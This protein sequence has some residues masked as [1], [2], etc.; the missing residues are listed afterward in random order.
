MPADVRARRAVT[1]DYLRSGNRYVLEHYDA[2]AMRRRH[3][4]RSTMRRGLSLVREPGLAELAFTGLRTP[5][6][7]AVAK[8][9]LFT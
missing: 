3:L 2:A 4:I 7:K 1:V 9:I 6:G 5:V 8:R